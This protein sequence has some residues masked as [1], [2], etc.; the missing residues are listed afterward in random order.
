MFYWYGLQQAMLSKSNQTDLKEHLLENQYSLN[1][2]RNHGNI[3][4]CKR[5]FTVFDTD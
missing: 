5:L 4:F 3:Y 1:Q 2:I